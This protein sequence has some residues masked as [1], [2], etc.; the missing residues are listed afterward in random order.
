M[1]VAR[2]AIE[3]ELGRIFPQAQIL[4]MDVDTTMSKLAHEVKFQ[5]FAEGK[6]QIM[7]GT[8]M[9]AKGLNFP[10]VT[11]VGVLNADQSIY[12]QDFRGCE[13]VFLC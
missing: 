3:D 12:S 7:V 4:R 10:N 8:Q 6:Y 9:V 2:S 11:L 13:R 1:E 5:E